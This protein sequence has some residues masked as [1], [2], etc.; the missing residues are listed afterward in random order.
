MIVLNN[1]R[2]SS[3]FQGGSNTTTIRCCFYIIKKHDN[4]WYKDLLPWGNTQDFGNVGYS[5]IRYFSR[6]GYGLK[7]AGEEVV[8]LILEFMRKRVSA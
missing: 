1:I 3:Y 2:R 4:Q 6:W 8:Q 5:C 7:D